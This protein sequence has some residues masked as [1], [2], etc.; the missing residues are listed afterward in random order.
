MTR[1]QRQMARLRTFYGLLPA[2]GRDPFRIFVWEV[3]SLRTTPA[4]RDAALAELKRLRALTPDAMWRTPPKR[5]EDAVAFAG[6]YQAQ[7]LRA[8]RVGVGLFRRSPTLPSILR[9]PIGPARRALTAFPPLGDG[10]IRR[11]LLFAAHRRVLGVDAHIVRVGLRL[12]YGEDE[13]RGRGLPGRSVRWAL[14]RDLAPDAD[15]FRQAT[16][17]LSH[18]AAATCVEADPHCSVCPLLGGVPRGWTTGS[19]REPLRPEGPGA[20]RPSIERSN[21]PAER[22]DMLPDLRLFLALL[23]VELTSRTQLEVGL[24][25]A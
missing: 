12:G 23:L 2:P 4:R 1:L 19:R 15:A 11:M 7:R 6:P 8:L 18:H 14:A 5:L 10:F 3:L 22:L 25:V 21:P 24:Q 20:G 9:G 16:V 13:G 17:Y